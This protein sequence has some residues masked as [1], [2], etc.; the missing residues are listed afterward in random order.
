MPKPTKGAFKVT[1][2]NN[3]KVCGNEIKRPSRF[4]TY[5]S[6]ECREKDYDKKYSWKEYIKTETPEK[7][8]K[9]L[10]QMRKGH[11]C[12][13]YVEGTVECKICGRWYVQVLTH[14]FYIHHITEHEY[15][16]EFDLPFKRGVV[17]S[18]Y[19]EKKAEIT[20]ENGTIENLKKG[21]KRRYIKGD[22]RAIINTGHKG[23]WGNKGFKYEER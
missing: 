2:L 20:K 3:C 5:C 12:D 11:G 21:A 22:P 6:T 1:I 23:R 4:R 19:R 14:A 8:E 7:R 16:E 18:W 9:R 13:H 17:P 15:K 10:A